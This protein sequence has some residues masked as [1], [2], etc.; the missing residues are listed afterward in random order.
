MMRVIES[1]NTET[2]Q[3][4]PCDYQFKVVGSA[5]L[6]ADFATLVHAA[7]NQVLPVALDAI[8][9][10]QSSKGTYLCV[11]VITYLHNEQQRQDIYQALQRIEGLKYLL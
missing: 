10:R 4:Y 8:K 2:L 7:I 9:H 6:D 5:D 1:D 3:E 11:T